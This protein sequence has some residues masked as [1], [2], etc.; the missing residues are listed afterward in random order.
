LT[1]PEEILASYLEASLRG[2]PDMANEMDDDSPRGKKGR[3]P[4]YP[5]S[6]LEVATKWARSLYD[7]EKKSPTSAQIVAQ[8]CGYANS[9]GGLSGPARTALSSLKKYGL[10]VDADDGRFRVSDDAVKYFLQPDEAEKLRILQSFALKPQIIRDIFDLYRDNLPSDDTLKFH[11]VT[12]LNFV[13]EGARTFIKAFRE[14]CTFAKLDPEAYNAL[15]NQ[16]APQVEDSAHAPSSVQKSIPR[17]VA[18]PIAAMQSNPC[19]E[20]SDG[21]TVTLLPSKPLTAET[22]SELIDYITVFGKVL[23]KRAKVVEP[24]PEQ[25]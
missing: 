7:R 17:A 4:N 3:S 15:M 2:D 12:T 14:T 18:Q 9:A 22:F 5:A 23:S 24:T 13:E 25:D 21:N 20:L 10:I 6:S 8:H 11:L 16:G 19:F 1:K